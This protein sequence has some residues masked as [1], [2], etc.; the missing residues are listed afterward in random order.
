[1]LPR[2]ALIVD[3]PIR[4][5]PSL[6]LVAMRLAQEGIQCY[7]VPMYFGREIWLLAPDF[8]LLNYLRPTNETFSQQLLEA[9]IKIGVLDSEGGVSPCLDQYYLRTLACEP[10]LRHRISCYFCWGLE[11]AEHLRQRGWFRDSQAIVT[12]SPRLDFYTPF[13]R[14]AALKV[15]PYADQYPSP[16]VLINGN[17]PFLNPRFQTP[18]QEARM[19][20]EKFGYDEENIAR[21]QFVQR[22]TMS[23]L[24]DLTNRLS[25]RFSN[26]TFIYRPHPFENLETYRSLLEPREN[27]HLVKKGTVD[28]WILRSSAVIQRNSSTAV[29]SA[30]AG[31][32]ALQPEWIPID[33]VSTVKDVSINCQTYEQICETLEAIISGSFKFPPYFQNQLDALIEDWFYRIDGRAHER[34][35]QGI[36]NHLPTNGHKSRVRRAK[37]FAYGLGGAGSWCQRRIRVALSSLFGLPVHWSFRKCG[38]RTPNLSWWAAS[39]KYFDSFH[40]VKLVNAIQSSAPQ[41]SGLRKK[42]VVRQTEPDRDYYLNSFGGLSVSLFVKESDGVSY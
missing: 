27:L 34:V 5:L 14:E 33:T 10:A 6:V 24:V 30:I 36:L 1:M 17:F 28:G 31:V 18:E 13:W 15:S 16:K 32:P 2:V 29:E 4:D 42:I 8:V 12:G 35:A 3:N 7:L 40:V 37:K 21:A 11:Q 38:P 39:E 20:I 23:G 9:G 25:A 19:M 26:A 41:R 22:Q